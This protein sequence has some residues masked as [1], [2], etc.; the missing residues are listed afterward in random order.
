MG[1]IEQQQAIEDESIGEI[2]LMVRSL[3]P[4]LTRDLAGKHVNIIIH[5][6]MRVSKVKLRYAESQK[7]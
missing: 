2:P 4:D 1:R 7:S 5:S 6:S 3:K